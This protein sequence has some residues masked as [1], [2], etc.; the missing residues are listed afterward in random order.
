MC[1]NNGMSL[2]FFFHYRKLRPKSVVDVDGPDYCPGNWIVNLL[3]YF[4]EVNSIMLTWSTCREKRA[5]MVKFDRWVGAEALLCDCNADIKYQPFIHFLSNSTNNSPN[6]IYL[7]Y[8][9]KAWLQL[10][11]DIVL[12]IMNC[13]CLLTISVS[14]SLNW[15]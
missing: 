3:R 10:C 2:T 4:W 8:F 5:N 7:S 14:S 6:S 13:I 1:E 9:N 12:H 15:K 11:F